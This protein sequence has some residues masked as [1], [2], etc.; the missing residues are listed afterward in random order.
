MKKHTLKTLGIMALS[1]TLLAS[2]LTGCG[3]TAE[4]ADVPGTEIVE[5]VE[6]ATEE[7]TEVP[8]KEAVADTE[9]VEEETEEIIATENVEETEQE[10]KNEK[11]A[12]TASDSSKGTA[13]KNTADKNTGKNTG[14]ASADTKKNN[15][16]TDK[17]SQQPSQPQTPPAENNAGT[18]QPNQ[19]QTP[20]T[21]NNAGT[22]QPSQPQTPPT[23]NN[24]DAPADDEAARRDEAMDSIDN[25]G[26]TITD[27]NLIQDAID[28]GFIEDGIVTQNPDG[29]ITF[30]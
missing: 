19:P 21:D 13:S 6:E 4:T 25:S 28:A 24:A 16:S 27:P 5:A 20:P 12:G 26:E 9:T 15:G 18:Q 22:Q 17:G 11:T 30:N 2:V 14:T 8:E 3:E 1:V 23:D 10:E 29:S 7:S